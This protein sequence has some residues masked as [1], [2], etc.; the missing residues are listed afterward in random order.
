MWTFHFSDSILGIRSR[1]S[2]IHCVIIITNT[3]YTN[4][5]LEDSFL[6]R[7]LVIITQHKNTKLFFSHSSYFIGNKIY[8]QCE[9]FNQPFLYCHKSKTC[10]FYYEF[11]SLAF[12]LLKI[13]LIKWILWFIDVVKLFDFNDF[14]CSATE[15]C[16]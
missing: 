4:T 5:H 12:F 14:H 11:Y 10:W 7:P 8:I 13:K 2:F 6:S 1:L 9:I 3:T 16:N 15:G